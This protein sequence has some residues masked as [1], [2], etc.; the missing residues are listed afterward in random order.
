MAAIS[1]EIKTI[2]SKARSRL[3]FMPLTT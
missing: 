3:F 2:K 1:S